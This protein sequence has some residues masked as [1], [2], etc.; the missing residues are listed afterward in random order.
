MTVRILQVTVE[1]ETFCPK[2]GVNEIRDRRLFRVL[3]GLFHGTRVPALKVPVQAQLCWQGN[4]ILQVFGEAKNG[5][6]SLSVEQV[7]GTQE[8]ARMIRRFHKQR[9]WKKNNGPLFLYRK[10]VRKLKGQVFVLKEL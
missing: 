2:P 8:P 6:L 4:G 1:G 9:I 10:P 7:Q 5:K 3:E